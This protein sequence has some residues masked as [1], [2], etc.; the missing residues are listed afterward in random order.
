MRKFNHAFTDPKLGF[1]KTMEAGYK[2]MDLKRV[3]YLGRQEIQ[4][5]GELRTKRKSF[6]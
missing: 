2:A 1:L 5:R 4:N 3:N 6:H